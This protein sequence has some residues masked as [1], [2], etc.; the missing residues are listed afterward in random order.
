MIAF[1]V[2]KT[3]FLLVLLLPIILLVKTNVTLL[4]SFN[5]FTTK[6]QLMLVSSILILRVLLQVVCNGA[7]AG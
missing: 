3:A 6:R 2:A 4:E 7:E 1:I 5:V